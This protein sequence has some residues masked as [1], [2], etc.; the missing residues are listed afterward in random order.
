VNEELRDWF[1]REG[2]LRYAIVGDERGEFVELERGPLVALG[3]SDDDF[4]EPPHPASTGYPGKPLAAMDLEDYNR[5]IFRWL[6]AAVA[7]SD[8][9]CAQCG[10]QILPGDD[11]PDPETWD[12]ILIE[13][14]L[15]SWMIVH[16]DCKKKIAKKLKGLHPFELTP[17]EPPHY[18]LSQVMLGP[19]E[20][21]RD[22]PEHG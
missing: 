4:V 9:Y 18:D 8:A 1:D 3:P 12:A 10:R 20:D 16:F 2:M 15:V 7:A 19:E 6:E 21:A 13:K 11:L 22:A 5:F 14:E 17:R